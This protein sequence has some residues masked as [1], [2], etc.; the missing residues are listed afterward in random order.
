MAKL[1][2]IKERDILTQV[3][4]LLNILQARGELMFV[5]VNVSG[6]ITDGPRGKTFRSNASMKGFPDL[7]LFLRGGKTLCVELKSPTGTLTESQVRFQERINRVGHQYYVV[8][9]YEYLRNVLDKYGCTV[10]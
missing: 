10:I 9:S 7:L 3:T 1:P 2:K 4:Y 8:R 6:I 5:R